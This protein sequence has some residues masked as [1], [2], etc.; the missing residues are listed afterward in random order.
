MNVEYYSG[1]NNLVVWFEPSELGFAVE[2]LRE[3]L[4]DAKKKHMHIPVYTEDFLKK[5]SLAK[6]KKGIVFNFAYLE[7]GMYF[8]QKVYTS[9]DPDETDI[10]SLGVTLNELWDSVGQYCVKD[11]MLH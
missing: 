2:T 10:A 1:D 5:L 11:D 7:V 4:D 9:V 3:S 8:L 6:T